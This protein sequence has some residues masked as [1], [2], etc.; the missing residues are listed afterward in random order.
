MARAMSDAHYFNTTWGEI[1]SLGYYEAEELLENQFQF[2]DSRNFLLD[3]TFQDVGISEIQG[4]LNG[5]P[6]QVIVQHFAGYVPPNYDKEIVD[7]WRTTLKQLREIQP[8]WS[9]LKDIFSIYDAHKDEVNRM[10]EIILIR[11]NNIEG[12]VSRM[13]ANQW[14]TSEQNR[15]I[16]NDKALYDEQSM[17]ATTLNSY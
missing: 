9:K 2:P 14:L 15:Y 7:S 1:P 10:N 12:I 17:L 16:E 11:I 3:K 4:E 8:G 6:T 5:C 13:E